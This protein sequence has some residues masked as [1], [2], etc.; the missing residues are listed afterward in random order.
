MNFGQHEDYTVGY[1]EH[2]DIIHGQEPEEERRS[3]FEY[4]ATLFES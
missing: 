1:I 4:E 3:R 2:E